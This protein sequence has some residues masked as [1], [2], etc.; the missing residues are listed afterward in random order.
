MMSL[1]PLVWLATLIIVLAG[2][3]RLSAQVTW[4]DLVFT[5]G[6]SGEGY[7]GN[8]P[9]ITVTAVDSATDVSSAVGEFGVRGSLFF[10]NR[11]ERT[12]QF[13]FDAG[14]RQFVS[15][16]FRTSDYAP[17]ELVGRV[18]LR[19]RE[20]L[21]TLGELWIMGGG[22]G[23]RVEDRPPMPMFIQ[24]GYGTVDG[25]VRLSLSILPRA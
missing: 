6:V 18:D 7:S 22:S 21:G 25:R 9:A 12:L 2:P 16:G 23:R 17:R 20:T 19:F 14:L 13:Q 8:L 10:L 4:Q 1:R 11:Q 24:P 5:G 3:A 15:A